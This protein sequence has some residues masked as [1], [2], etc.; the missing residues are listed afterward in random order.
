[1]AKM[2]RPRKFRSAA[3]MAELWEEYKD[4]C[5]HYE[6]RLTE[7]SAKNSEFV[8]QKVQKCI[9]YTIEGFCVFSEIS[10]AKFYSTYADDPAFSDIVTRMR[11]ECEIDARRK[12]EI[13][14]IPPQ[15]AAL[16]MS[17][18]GYSLKA[19]PQTETQNELLKSLQALERG[20]QA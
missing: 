1:M 18:H 16:W 9:T 3:R 8:T 7:F 10:R 6:V 2:G 14:A 11:E 13:G 20:T 17:K 12:F 4:Y 15:L 5:D 19:E